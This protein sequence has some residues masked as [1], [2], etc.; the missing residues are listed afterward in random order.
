MSSFLKYVVAFLGASRGPEWE[1]WKKMEHS[2]PFSADTLSVCLLRCAH[3]PGT[4]RRTVVSAW[5][6]RHFW[7]L[8]HP[9][10][11][12]G[13]PVLSSNTEVF[14]S[15]GEGTTSTLFRPRGNGF[16]I[17]QNPFSLC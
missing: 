6:Q 3:H 12:T 5:C 1:T 13:R 16:R 4:L 17:L 15:S 9:D 2:A 11:H 8:S 10:G 7:S 14:Y